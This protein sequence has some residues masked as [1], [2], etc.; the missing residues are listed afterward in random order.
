MPARSGTINRLSGTGGS[1]YSGSS[2]S[3]SPRRQQ[4]VDQPAMSGGDAA[5]GDHRLPCCEPVIDPEPAAE[6]HPVDLLIRSLQ[7]QQVAAGHVH[8]A[9]ALMV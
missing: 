5:T 8:H 6:R 1:R 7:D 4:V 9:D 2:T 3:K